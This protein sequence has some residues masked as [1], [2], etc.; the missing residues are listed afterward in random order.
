MLDNSK[1]KTNCERKTLFA[2]DR[3]YKNIIVPY[4]HVY[5]V[6]EEIK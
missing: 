5:I 6:R 1:F 2:L 3:N 4:I